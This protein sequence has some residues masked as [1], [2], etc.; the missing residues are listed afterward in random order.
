[1]TQMRNNNDVPEKVD[2]EQEDEEV[3]T[4]EI[5]TPTERNE[6]ENAMGETQPEQEAEVLVRETI[7]KEIQALL[8]K[9]EKTDVKEE[10]RNKIQH[11]KAVMATV[12]ECFRIFEVM[13]DQALE[14]T[15]IGTEMHERSRNVMNRTS[16]ILDL[17]NADKLKNIT[18]PQLE[19]ICEKMQELNMRQ[20]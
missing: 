8:D 1:M 5:D 3:E 4:I 15:E 9:E 18:R 10:C 7:V 16:K 19:M 17:L 12:R 11:Y 2:T 6:E 20:N 14:D 13:G